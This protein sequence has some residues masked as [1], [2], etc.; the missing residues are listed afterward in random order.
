MGEMILEHRLEKAE[1]EIEVMT[2]YISL[3]L[4]SNDLINT[5]EQFKREM[6]KA[7]KGVTNGE[8]V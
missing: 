7:R 2:E 4:R 1:R 3:L 8:N 5:A 6:E